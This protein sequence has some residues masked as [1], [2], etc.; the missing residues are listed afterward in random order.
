MPLET[1]LSLGSKIREQNSQNA[2]SKRCDTCGLEG[3]SL[4]TC[5]RC[6]CYWYCN[7]VGRYSHR[8]SGLAN[9]Y[10]ACQKQG[11]QQ[12]GHRKDCRHAKEIKQLLLFDW[13]EFSRHAQF[14]L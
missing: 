11:W 7:K 4:L 13:S 1:A 14:P 5:A 8:L 10:Q 6:K 9:A 12:G 2:A 3:N